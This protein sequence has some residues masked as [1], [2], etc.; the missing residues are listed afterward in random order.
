MN[1]AR[2]WTKEAAHSYRS[3]INFAV[4]ATICAGSRFVSTTLA[5]NSVRTAST[6]GDVVSVTII[7][8]EVG[9]LLISAT[10]PI[11]T[12]TLPSGK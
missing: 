5:N 7:D 4:P 3:V 2:P 11:G 8:L 9:V 6:F 1:A 12:S 10:L